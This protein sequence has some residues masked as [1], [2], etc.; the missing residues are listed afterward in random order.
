[1]TAWGPHARDGEATRVGEATRLRLLL[2]QQTAHGY[3]A[4]QHFLQR[5][6]AAPGVCTP[7]LLHRLPGS[8]SVPDPHRPSLYQSHAGRELLLRRD[9]C[10][11]CRHLMVDAG[12]TP[13]AGAVHT[14]QGQQYLSTV[15]PSTCQRRLWGGSRGPQHSTLPNKLRVLLSTLQSNRSL[16]PVLLMP[17]H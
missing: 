11:V 2:L 12:H 15:V 14:C 13:T 1:M 3:T 17:Q 5:L 9:M 8:R 10:P 16:F 7:D 6:W 4:T